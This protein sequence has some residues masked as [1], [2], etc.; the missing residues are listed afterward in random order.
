MNIPYSI[1]NKL[2]VPS[3]GKLLIVRLTI[4]GSFFFF[5]F[6]KLN[7]PT[8]NCK[9]KQQQ[10][11][12]QIE[13]QINTLQAYF[14]STSKLQVKTPKRPTLR[15]VEEGGSFPLQMGIKLWGETKEEVQP[16][17]PLSRPYKPH[18]G[19]RSLHFWIYF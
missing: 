5:F 1:A 6:N 13:L 15:G 10:A 14:L 17:E 8:T 18:K 11:A 2:H 4:T 7:K 12:K 3:L 9:L 16:R 19:R